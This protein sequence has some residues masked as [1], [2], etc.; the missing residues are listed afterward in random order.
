MS[1]WERRKTCRTT[2]RIRI[3]KQ[4]MRAPSQQLLGAHSLVCVPRKLTLNHDADKLLSTMILYIT[5]LLLLFHF[6]RN[7]ALCRTFNRCLRFC[8]E[9]AR[10]R[11]EKARS[12]HDA[13]IRGTGGC[14]VLPVTRQLISRF[15]TNKS[16]PA[17]L[18]V[19]VVALHRV[20]LTPLPQMGYKYCIAAHSIFN[21]T[22]IQ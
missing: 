18:L 11:L 20:N 6:E 21:R 2:L 8:R 10:A 15:P 16:H 22:Q 1:P 13:S 19:A 9:W 5:L 4:R 17:R 14:C 12:K 7:T 3:Y